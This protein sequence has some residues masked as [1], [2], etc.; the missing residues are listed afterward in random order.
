MLK[1]TFHIKEMDCPSEENLIRMKLEGVEHVKQLDFDLTNR[2]LGVYHTI[3]NEEI[4]KSLE[5]LNLG[6]KLIRTDQVDDSEIQEESSQKKI[7]W[8]VLII[9][10]VFFLLEMTTGV[11]SESMG[12]VADSLDML[13]DSIVYG[14]SLFAVG[15]TVLMKKNIS[16]VAGYFQIV[17]AGIGFVEVLRRFFGIESV[18]DFQTMIIISI[19]A[20]FA[21]GLCLYIL[22]RSRSK[23]AHMQASMIFTSNDIIINLGV[24]V[25]GLL[26]MWTGSNKPD[27]VIG[28]IVFVLVIKGAIRIL[29]LSKET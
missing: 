29:A 2:E 13:A 14:L 18:P 5:A 27:L 4:A 19:L 16:K 6:S 7:L 15:G 8:A 28:S 3:E 25:A 20:L 12:L 17:L 24:V 26:V 21:N 11:V 23:E 9:N 1:S 10:F 22:Q